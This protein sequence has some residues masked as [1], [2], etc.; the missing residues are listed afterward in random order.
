MS[1]TH[2]VCHNLSLEELKVLA[3][4]GGLDFEGLKAASKC[5]TGCG[6]CEPYVRLMLATGRT[7][8]PVLSKA[9]IERIVSVNAGGAAARENDG[10]D[11][12]KRC[13]GG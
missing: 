5:S 6:L 2:C 8:F 10:P 13:S 9:E 12:V 7:R 3:A 1:V 4:R 11:R